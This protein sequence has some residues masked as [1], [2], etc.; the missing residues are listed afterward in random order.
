MAPKVKNSQEVS[1]STV[2]LFVQQINSDYGSKI[3]HTFILHGNIYDYVDNGGN[4]LNIKTV[5]SSCYDD[6]VITL[7]SRGIKSVKKEVVEPGLQSSLL[8][9]SEKTRIIV[10]FNSALGTEI[11]NSK[12]FEIWK[13]AILSDLSAD[14]KEVAGIQGDRYYLP[15]DVGGA[16][17]LFNRWF[18]I[19]KKLRAQNQYSQETSGVNATLVPEAV[20]TLVFTDSDTIFPAGVVSQLGGDRTPIVFMRNWAQ[21]SE[22]IGDR[23]RIIMMTRH[24]SDIHESIRGE[25]A[26][27]YLVKKPDLQ[28]R[29]EYITNFN[30]NIEARAAAS[31]GGLGI[32][33]GKNLCVTKIN[34]APDFTLEE[35][36]VQSAGMNRRQIKDVIFNSW[37]NETPIDFGLVRERKKRALDDEYN[38]MLDIKEPSFGFDQIGGHEHFKDYCR[39][40]IIKPLKEG[41]KKLCSRGA[42]MTGPPGTGKSMVA[43]ALAKEAGLNF[44][45]VDLS[46]VF[47]G[48][49]GQ[50]ESN[51]RKLIEAVEAAAPCIVFVD[52]IDSVLSSGRSSAGDSGTSGRVFNSFMS[53]LSDPG[54][55][56]KVVC[57]AAS[58]R[59]DLL[60]AALIRTG[61]MDV[62]I[63]MLPPA[64]GDRSGRL[65]IL[66]ALSKKHKIAFSKELL[67]TRNDATGLG[68]LLGDQ[69]RIWTG[70]EIEQ[71]LQAGYR[72]SARSD[73][74]LENG[75]QDLTLTVQ[76]WEYAMENILPN[77]KEVTKM[78][79]LSLLYCDNLSYVPQAWKKLASNKEF[80]EA[81]LGL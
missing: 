41:N 66:S 3:S 79:N 59:P 47:G 42:L 37:R 7:N 33:L 34:F 28:D 16:L 58:N 72:K 6:N 61:R 51:M 52:E 14:E 68:L 18:A 36:A 23:S 73:R 38:G 62:K 27:S 15:S 19:S 80:L 50:T 56:G 46:K 70:A 55:V 25:L 67:E 77:T 60:D 12:S 26:V 4:D 24:M 30:R 11:P 53:W 2:P 43:W 69:I 44:I 35:F 1:S 71:V 20:L 65:E 48:L 63:P 57:L 5:L 32:Q 76:D 21:D 74:K 13:K 31:A 29:R 64:I 17:S 39:W 75:N 10:F 40:E 9:R 49:V 8:P 45:Q 81:E 78:I 22:G 54:R